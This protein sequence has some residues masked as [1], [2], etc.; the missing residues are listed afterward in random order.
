MPEQ[1]VRKSKFSYTSVLGKI[2]GKHVVLKNSSNTLTVNE[3]GRKKAKCACN[4]AQNRASIER[5]INL[6]P[7]GNEVEWTATEVETAFCVEVI[8]FT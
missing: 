2:P 3:K 1:N 5:F 4:A 6:G 8:V 7:I